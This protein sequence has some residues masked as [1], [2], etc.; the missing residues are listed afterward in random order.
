MFKNNCYLTSGVID[1]LELEIQ[2]LLWE[3]IEALDE[4]KDFLQVFEVTKLADGKS[5]IE[6]WQEDP[7]YYSELIIDFI[8]EKDHLEISVIDYGDYSM[9]LLSD[10]Y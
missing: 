4:P 3:M 9:M 7:E 8:P 2:I 6:H 5:K 1:E 10:D